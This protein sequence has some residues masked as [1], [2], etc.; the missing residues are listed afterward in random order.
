MADPHNS[1]GR[2]STGHGRALRP[3]WS[4]FN[5]RAADKMLRPLILV[6]LVFTIFSSIYSPLLSLQDWNIESRTSH[7]VFAG[8]KYYQRALADARALQAFWVTGVFITGAVAA[9]ILC[10]LLI[11]LLLHPQQR[12]TGLTRTVI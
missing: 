2:V 11:A 5:S 1:A 4:W 6:L 3:L 10:G 12:G 7:W 9:E 8:L